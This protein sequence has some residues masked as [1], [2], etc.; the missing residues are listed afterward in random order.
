DYSTFTGRVAIGRLHRGILKEGMN[1][2]LVK[3]DGKIVK[4]KIKELQTFEGLGRK[5][6][7]E[8]HAGDICA[9]VGIEG[10]EIGDV[11]ADFENPEALATIT[12]DE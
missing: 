8:V 9:V 4:S 3:R 5:K 12:I 10:F 1:I 2:S 6:V 11:I 7:S